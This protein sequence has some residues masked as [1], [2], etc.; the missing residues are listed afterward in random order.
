MAPLSESFPA[1]LGDGFFAAGAA[2]VFAAGEAVAFGA[3]FELSFVDA[4]RVLGAL[5]WARDS[6][7]AI[8]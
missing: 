4:A 8:P 2:V 1:G 6:S 3:G 5:P 7:A